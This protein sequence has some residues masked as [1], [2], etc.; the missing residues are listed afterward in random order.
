[1]ILYY[2][3]YGNKKYNGFDYINSLRFSEDNGFR[4]KILEYN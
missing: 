3:D 2:L 4:T 1:M